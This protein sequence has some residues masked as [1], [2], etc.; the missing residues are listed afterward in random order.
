MRNRRRT[1]AALVDNRLTGDYRT[2]KVERFS[3]VE[4]RLACS[5]YRCRHRNTICEFCVAAWRL[6]YL[7]TEP[8]PWDND[9]LTPSDDST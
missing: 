3:Q 4:L 9:L 7:F 2:G 1:V 5:P 8:L 6:E